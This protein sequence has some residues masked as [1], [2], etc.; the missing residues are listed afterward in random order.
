MPFDL[1]ISGNPNVLIN[2]QGI[3]YGDY[4]NKSLN[5]MSINDVIQIS[6]GKAANKLKLI[7][8]YQSAQLRSQTYTNRVAKKNMPEL[9]DLFNNM[10]TLNDLVYLQVQGRSQLE[11]EIEETPR[12]DRYHLD[13]A[14]IHRNEVTKEVEKEG[15]NGDS[16]ESL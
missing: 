14:A 15:K 9:K 8:T 10:N 16:Q 5:D 1:E 13:E 7:E 4:I 12:S 6:E 3:S 11:K 2:K